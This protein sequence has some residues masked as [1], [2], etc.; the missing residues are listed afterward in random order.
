MRAVRGD[1][2]VG[3]EEEE[4]LAVACIEERVCGVRNSVQYSTQTTDEGWTMNDVRWILTS[5]RSFRSASV[6]GRMTTRCPGPG[7]NAFTAN[8]CVSGSLIA[9]RPMWIASFVAALIFL[10]ASGS[11]YCSVA[12][13]TSLEGLKCTKKL[14]SNTASAPSDLSSSKFR[15][16]AVLATL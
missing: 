6:G 10:I 2:G 1:G 4:L 13:D 12:S 7:P 16:E 8:C 9:S 14:T 11:L 15:A 3:L 5:G